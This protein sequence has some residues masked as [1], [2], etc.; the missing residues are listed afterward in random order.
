[1]HWPFAQQ[2]TLPKRDDFLAIE[3]HLVPEAV[4]RAGRRLIIGERKTGRSLRSIA[5]GRCGTTGDIAT[6]KLVPQFVS[7]CGEI[8]FPL[9]DRRGNDLNLF[10]NRQIETG[11]RID[12]L[13]IVGQQPD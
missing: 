9:F 13:W 7:F 5:G 1:M 4:I 2:V 10:D 3:N 12:L 8:G 11:E 6:R